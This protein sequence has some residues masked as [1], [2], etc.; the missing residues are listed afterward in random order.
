MMTPTPASH[1]SLT[2]HLHQTRPTL[3]ISRIRS[4]TPPGARNRLQTTIRLLWMKLSLT[5]S[6]DS[7]HWPWSSFSLFVAS[8]ALWSYSLCSL[9][10]SPLSRVD[11]V[12][13]AL[14]SD[15]LDCL[16]FK[17]NHL[18]K[19]KTPFRPSMQ[20]RRR[21]RKI[22][23]SQPSSSMN[24]HFSSFPL[25][26]AISTSSTSRPTL[27]SH[28]SLSLSYRSATLKKIKQASHKEKSTIVLGNQPS[29]WPASLVCCARSLEK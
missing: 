18:W 21:T 11:M 13:P 28:S 10:S 20:M 7:I 15:I 24:L 2:C 22:Q 5:A 8:W 17:A 26:S 27:F 23:S 19:L 6:N 16:T 1:R 14:T 12:R 25:L 29:R 3:S 4:I 9:N